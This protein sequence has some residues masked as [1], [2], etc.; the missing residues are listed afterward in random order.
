[1]KQDAIERSI[2]VRMYRRILGDCFLLTYR[3]AEETRYILIDCGILQGVE[4]GRE[5]MHEIV[6]D[7]YK[8]TGGHLH[9]LV[10]THE[11]HDH[12]SG[13]LYEQERFFGSEGFVVDE[14]WLA[15]TENPAD[16]QAQR[17]RARFDRSR[18]AL[19]QAL[20]ATALGADNLRVQTI[21][22]L[23]RFSMRTELEDEQP[24]AAAKKTKAKAKD[25]PVQKDKRR[26]IERLVDRVG[27]PRVRYL[28]PG[29]VVH[30]QAVKALKTYVLGPPRDEDDLRRDSPRDGEGKEVYLLGADEAEAVLQRSLRL[31]DSATPVDDAEVPFANPHRR[32][33]VA[34]QKAESPA[35]AM[36]LE[37]ANDW[38]RIDD[39]WLNSAETLAL[40]MDSDTNNTSLVLAFEL[41]DQQVLLFPGDAQVG[42]WLSWHRQAY[43]KPAAPGE[44]APISCDDILSRVTFYKVGHHCSHNATLRE[45]G[46]EKMNDPRLVAMIPVVSEVAAKQRGG[47]GWNMPYPELLAALNRHARN[48]VI[49][50]DGDMKL[51]QESFAAAPT[52]PRKPATLRYGENGVWVELNVRF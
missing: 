16:A 34:G 27:A 6:D 15:W 50:G 5:L 44:P 11:H 32:P 21:R 45:M 3:A 49:R 43:P 24:L 12:Q 48:R 13:F 47:Q 51:E 25:S 33:F 26:I 36:Y 14:L 42:N 40:K 2:E 37:A 38:R 29:Q 1:M 9:L 39:E 46:L 18:Q 28:E 4:R 17:L 41:E 52:D 8:T 10:L 30:P 35:Q 20:A 19:R 23:A 31:S 7:L 22:D